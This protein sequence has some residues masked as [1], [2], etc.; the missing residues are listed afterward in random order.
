MSNHGKSNIQ[1]YI[2]LVD[3]GLNENIYF[4]QF[5]LDLNYS[6]IQKLFLFLK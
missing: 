3:M 1:I 4:V 5:L 6:T 2:K